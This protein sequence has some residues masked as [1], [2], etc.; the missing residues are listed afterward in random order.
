MT[1]LFDTKD[2]L[3]LTITAQTAHPKGGRGGD[4]HMDGP[5]AKPGQFR[6]ASGHGSHG[7]PDGDIIFY[8]GDHERMRLGADGTV[9]I[10]GEVV[11]SNAT[12]YA[13]FKRWIEG[14][15]LLIENVA[16]EGRHE[17]SLT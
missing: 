15:D 2:G 5:A 11:A 10:R 9:T 14:A 13:E 6:L 4:V 7:M 17:G 8:T 16:H 3:P 1:D 12:V